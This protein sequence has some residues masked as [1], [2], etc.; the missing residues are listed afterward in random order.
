MKSTAFDSRSAKA[1]F[2]INR[3][4]R[5]RYWFWAIL[6]GMVIC[7]FIPWTQNIKTKGNVTTLKQEQ[8]PQKLNSPI[9]G[10]IA[11]W[12]VKEGDFVKKGDTI[13]TL[14]EIK[15]DYLDPKLIGRTQQQVDAKKG[16]IDFYRN[17]INTT[18]AQID[19]L[20]EL[21]ELKLA[22]LNNKLSQLNNKLTG[23]QAELNAA[24]NETDLLKNQ[25]ERQQK[26]YDQGLVSQTQLQQRSIQYQNAVSKKTIC[27][28]KVAQTKQEIT[29][30]GIEQRSVKQEYAEKINKAEGEKFQYLSQIATTEGEVSKLENQVANY[31]IR[32]Q[33]YI[34][35]AP[36]DGQIVQANKSGIGEILKDGETIA[37]IVPRRLNYAVE[38]FVNPMDLP[39]VNIGQKVRFVFD[40]FPAIIFS[41][42]PE[43]SYGTFTGT[44]VAME[45]SIGPNGKYRVLVA[46]D[47]SKKRWP[48]QLTLGTG[49]Q[50]ILLLKD[51]PIWYELWRNING[52][53]P[54]FYTKAND[55]KAKD[56]K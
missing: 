20:V 38:I 1:I 11:R 40:G 7:L 17:K 30:T 39:L 10:R 45:S 23:E 9:P 13:I 14:T 15:E 25:Y 48:G 37:L 22:Q 55:S 2:Q 4:S 46:E 6:I 29:N 50:G 8:R 44:V 36:Q 54:D 19:N 41:G 26:L 47:N 35:T 24:E 33:M 12:F 3:R 52:F 53:P 5:I 27:E 43:N 28:N 51:V 16:S 21:R 49:A 56:T 32:N 34:I 18:T 42:W 31:T